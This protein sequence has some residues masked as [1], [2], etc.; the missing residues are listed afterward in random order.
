[1]NIQKAINNPLLLLGGLTGF[2]FLFLAFRNVGLYPSVF[3]DEYTYS[4]LSRL[5]PLSDSSIP[6]YVFLKLYSITNCCGDGF[7]GCAKLIN[8]VLFVAAA[9]FIYLVSKS[10]ASSSISLVVSLLA[11]LGPINSYTA[12]F[13]PESFFFFSF[14][15]LCWKLLNLTSESGKYVWFAAGAIYAFSALIKP[16]SIFL[17]PAVVTYIAFIFLKG[18]R[19]FCWQSGLAFASFIVGATVT[20]FGI[21][22]LLA[23]SAGLTLFGPLYSSIASSTASGADKYIQLLPL[24]LESFKGHITVVAL[25]YGLPL[26]IAVVITADA[27][28]GKSNPDIEGNARADTFERIAVLSSVILLN[29]VCVVAL[30]TASVANSGPPETPY[31]L[32][33]RYYNFALPLFYIVAAG[34]LSKTIEINRNVRYLVGA[35]VAI[36]GVYAIWT[37]LAPYTP[38]YV[39][40]PEIRGLHVNSA[41][42]KIVGILAISS[43]ALWLVSKRRGLQFYCYLA[44]PL[45]VAVSA[46][47]VAREMN[48]RLTLDIYDTAGIFAKQYLADEDLSKV[49][50]V[51]SEAGGLFKSLYYLDNAKASLEILPRDV[52][53]DLGKMS[54]D[55]SWIL[56]VGDHELM[57]KSFYQV[58]MNGFTLVRA[59]KDDAIDFKKRAWPGIILKSK[60][61][62]SPEPWGTWSQSDTVAFE[63]AAPL[64]GEF[65]IHLV[66]RAFGPNAG[67]EFEASVGESSAKFRLSTNDEKT[68][69]KLKNP[70]GV[71]VVRIKIPNPVSPKALGLSGDDRYLGIGF[72]E[73]RIV[74][75]D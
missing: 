42:F 37:N 43:L 9:P 69:I 44:L 35:I 61:L 64:P 29:L 33:M 63:F 60:G 16:H 70:E 32:H 55:K 11:I 3:A 66:A 36:L 28:V 2:V 8:A 19:L 34:G 41:L 21:S 7:L 48:N 24:A 62:S 12:Y 15:V 59:S 71:R 17:L 49:V 46:Y 1:M 73:M 56:V 13:M 65:E 72:V 47:H 52:A 5:L 20:K 67:S 38:N 40:S 58:S 4:K 68:I 51:G 18:P 23:G 6:G 25:V 10:V 53:F 31:R 27:V 54:P 50:V 14:W 57:G 39:D 22:Y 74:A 45:F 26:T 75:S 30:F